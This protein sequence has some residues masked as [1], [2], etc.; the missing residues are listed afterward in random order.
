LDGN[1]V[2]GQ[3]PYKPWKK[4]PILVPLGTRI[5][6][7]WIFATLGDWITRKMKGKEL[8]IPKYRKA[9]GLASSDT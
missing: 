5:G 4:A 1:P 6:N 2:E 7:S 8:F 3:K 9:F